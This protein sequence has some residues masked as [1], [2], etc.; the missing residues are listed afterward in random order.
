MPNIGYTFVQFFHLLALSIWIG[1]TIAIGFLT[2]PTLI[3]SLP[4]RAVAGGV[5]GEILAKF[6][7]IKGVCCV[8]LVATSIL[9]FINWERHWNVWFAARYLAIVAMVCTALAAGWG[10]APALRAIRSDAPAGDDVSAEPSVRFRELHR[11][12]VLLTRAGLVA[13][14]VALTLS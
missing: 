10:I 14:L 4:D 2:A 1:G 9:K 8:A 5:M 3:R 6:D 13:A 11:A 12:S 7:R